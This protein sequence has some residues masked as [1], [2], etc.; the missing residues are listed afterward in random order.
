MA[1][2]AG[3]ADRGEVGAS[4][5]LRSIPLSVWREAGWRLP[6]KYEPAV[7]SRAAQPGWVYT[8]LGATWAALVIYGSLLPFAFGVPAGLSHGGA[9]LRPGAW[10]A[11]V[12]PVRWH[13]LVPWRWVDGDGPMN[14]A[15][16]MPIGLLCRMQL[17][18]RGRSLWVQWFWPVL[19]AGGLSCLV[20]AAQIFLPARVTSAEDVLMNTAGGAL[21][22]WLLVPAVLITRRTIFALYCTTAIRRARWLTWCRQRSPRPRLAAGIIAA[23]VAAV[24][25]QTSRHPIGAGGYVDWRPFAAAFW[26][27]YD[28]GILSLARELLLWTAVVSIW[29]VAMLAGGWRVHFVWLALA[30]AALAVVRGGIDCLLLYRIADATDVV[31]AA[32][33]AGVLWLAVWTVKRAVKASNRRKAHRDVPYERRRL[34]HDYDRR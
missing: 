4:D 13:D 8:L 2:N 34:P 24:L 14:V 28:A 26:L 27:N 17:R 21:G 12:L 25:L 3:L 29:A 33:S 30:A 11:Q 1:N 7:R 9:W 16:Y 31:L 10:W 20:E 18:T 6:R 32:G 15:L 19:L 5:F 23:V 22:A